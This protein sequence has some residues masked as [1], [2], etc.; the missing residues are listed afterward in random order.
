M[1]A[2]VYSLVETQT[3][4]GGFNWDL[5]SQTY[6][7][8]ILEAIS[9]RRPVLTEAYMLPNMSDPENVAEYESWK[10]WFRNMISPEDVSPPLVNFRCFSSPCAHLMERNFFPCNLQ[11]PG[12]PATDLQ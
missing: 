11:D 1:P 10:E 5:L 7:E 4:S 8:A 6:P 3:R 12:E 2:S 9:S